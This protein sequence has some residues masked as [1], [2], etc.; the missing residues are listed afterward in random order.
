MELVQKMVAMTFSDS[1]SLLKARIQSRF[2]DAIFAAIFHL[3][4][5]LEFL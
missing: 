2:F 4:R 5:L 1:L 3:S